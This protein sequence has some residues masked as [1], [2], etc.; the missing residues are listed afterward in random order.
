VEVTGENDGIPY[1]DGNVSVVYDNLASTQSQFEYDS[2]D[3]M[4]RGDW[5]LARSRRQGMHNQTVIA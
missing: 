2:Q 1:L 4:P 3:G 5:A